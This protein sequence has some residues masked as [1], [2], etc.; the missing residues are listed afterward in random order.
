MAVS[1]YLLGAHP[2]SIAH[3]IAAG[4]EAEAKSV[5]KRILKRERKRERKQKRKQKY[6]GGGI[7]SE[8][9]CRGGSKSGKDGV[10]GEREQ[11]RKL[12]FHK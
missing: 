7:E 3:E 5:Q 9:G 12:E 2:W 11:E 1:G 8:S 6:S 4:A 10:R